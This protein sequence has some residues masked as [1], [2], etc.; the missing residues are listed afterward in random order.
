MKPEELAVGH[1][2]IIDSKLAILKG[3]FA[4]ANANVTS[5]T[6]NLLQQ[7]EI[8]KDGFCTNC[9]GN[10]RIITRVMSITRNELNKTKHLIKATY[11]EGVSSIETLA[12][13]YITWLR[14]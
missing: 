2:K 10:K 14:K 3:V 4:N 1:S 7:L 12:T 5:K 13:E 9:P 11:G 8:N 6:G